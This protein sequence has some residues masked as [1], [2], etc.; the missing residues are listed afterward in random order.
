MVRTTHSTS[1]FRSI[2]SNPV[3]SWNGSSSDGLL[4]GREILVIHTGSWTGICKV[5][6]CVT[7]TK[8]RIN[9]NSGRYRF[10]EYQEIQHTIIVSISICVCAH[11]EGEKEGR[12][13]ADE[14]H[15]HKHLSDGVSEST[16]KRQETTL[17]VMCFID[18]KKNHSKRIFLTAS[19]SR[20]IGHTS[21][22]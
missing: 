1:K 10:C 22:R 14:N 19:H 20:T 2:W 16:N 5:S 12:E 18:S 8:R 6:R 13:T 3:I 15:S 7:G 11:I 21:W 4:L 9:R 17:K